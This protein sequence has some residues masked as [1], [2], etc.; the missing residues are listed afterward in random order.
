LD[1]SWRTAAEEECL[2][3]RTTILPQALSVAIQSVTDEKVTKWDR[4]NVSPTNSLAIL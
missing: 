4:F 2:L 1:L 3:N